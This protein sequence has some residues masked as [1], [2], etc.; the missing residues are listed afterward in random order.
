MGRWLGR[1]IGGKVAAAVV[2]AAEKRGEAAVVNEWR[3]RIWKMKEK[4]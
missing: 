4:I 2:A 1:S 3:Q